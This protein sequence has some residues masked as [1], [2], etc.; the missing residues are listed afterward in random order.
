MPVKLSAVT[1]SDLTE[2][3]KCCVLGTET[4]SVYGWPACK[5]WT[6]V[7]IRVIS[8]QATVLFCMVCPLFWKPVSWGT[9]RWV[10]VPGDRLAAEQKLWTDACSCVHVGYVLRSVL[11]T[12]LVSVSLLFWAPLREQKAN[13]HH[14]GILQICHPV[15]HLSVVYCTRS[16]VP[17]AVWR[18]W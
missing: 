4:S 15:P 11:A 7:R 16:S 3:I 6:S 13:D 14:I 1:L 12:S 8:V 2:N 5:H 10:I 18:Q 9:F 17:P